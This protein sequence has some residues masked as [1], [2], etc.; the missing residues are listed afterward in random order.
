MRVD[1]DSYIVMHLRYPGRWQTACALHLSLLQ[2]LS[3]DMLVM[4]PN[5]TGDSIAMAEHGKV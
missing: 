4:H 5:E 3:I 2:G 1:S